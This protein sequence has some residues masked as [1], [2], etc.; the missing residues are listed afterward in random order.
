[1]NEKKW[2][3]VCSNLKC[4]PD[5]SPWKD[6]KNSNI[7]GKV[8]KLIFSL[9]KNK[10]LKRM[11]NVKK[12]LLNIRVPHHVPHEKRMCLSKASRLKFSI[13]AGY[14]CHNLPLMNKNVVFQ[15]CY[16][17]VR[18]IFGKLLCSY[19]KLNDWSP[20]C[21]SKGRATELP[22]PTRAALWSAHTP[23]FSNFTLFRCKPSLHPLFLRIAEWNNAREMG[24]VLEN[25]QFIL[26]E[27]PGAMQK[28]SCLLLLAHSFFYFIFFI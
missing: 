8:Q 17:S 4:F 27:K 15:G 20:C 13:T 18:Y 5:S 19:L 9:N 23:P 10:M 1:M 11:W 6:F 2:K 26:V 12:T 24:S 21:G 16:V 3:N 22:A 25:Q 7:S 14:M 28:R